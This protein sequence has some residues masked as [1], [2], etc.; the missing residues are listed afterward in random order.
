MLSKLEQQSP[1]TPENETTPTQLEMTIVAEDYPCFCHLLFFITYTGSISHSFT[2]HNLHPTSYKPKS[3]YIEIS[4]R[5]PTRP[6]TGSSKKQHPE[7]SH[8]HSQPTTPQAKRSENS[9]TAVAAPSNTTH[10]VQGRAGQADRAGRKR[11]D[12]HDKRTTKKIPTRN[13]QKPRS[14]PPSGGRQ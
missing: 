2:Y 13:P 1:F 14:A 3:G 10:T 5:P 11:S 9:R 4:Q 6:P 8:S 12:H 7:K